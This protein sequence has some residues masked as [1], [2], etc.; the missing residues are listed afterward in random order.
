MTRAYSLQMGR[1]LPQSTMCKEERRERKAHGMFPFVNLDWA[2][3][4][5]EEGDPLGEKQI[6]KVKAER[7]F[8]RKKAWKFVTFPPPP[9]FFGFS[10]STNK[11]MKGGGNPSQ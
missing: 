10:P 2:G 7:G 3:L 1:E 5:F 9:F 11:W 6:G 8:I 4:G